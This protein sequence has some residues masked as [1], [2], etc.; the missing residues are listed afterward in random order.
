M[1]KQNLLL[2]Q[3]EEAQLI[4]NLLSDPDDALSQ[5]LL[6]L[7]WQSMDDRTKTKETDH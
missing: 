4:K 5:R 1:E 3:C 6:Q 7:H 2:T